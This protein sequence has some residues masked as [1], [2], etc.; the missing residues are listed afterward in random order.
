MILQPKIGELR[1]AVQMFRSGNVLEKGQWVSRAMWEKSSETVAEGE[2]PQLPTMINGEPGKI[3]EKVKVLGVE[4]EELRIL[5]ASGTAK[6]PREHLS[7]EIQKKYWG[8]PIARQKVEMVAGQENRKVPD[9]ADGTGLREESNVGSQNDVVLMK[10]PARDDLS[11]SGTEWLYR[12]LKLYKEN[13]IAV[14]SKYQGEKM[15]LTGEV[16]RVERDGSTQLPLILLSPPVNEKVSPPYLVVMLN[17]FE[18]A[19]TLKG[20]DIITLTGDYFGEQDFRGLRLSNGNVEKVRSRLEPLPWLTYEFVDED[21]LRMINPE[22]PI[23]QRAV[24]LFLWS[25]KYPLLKESYDAIHNKKIIEVFLQNSKGTHHLVQVCMTGTS[26]GRKVTTYAYVCVIEDGQ[27]SF[28]VITEND[29]DRLIQVVAHCG[30]EP[31]PQL[32]VRLM[33]NNSWPKS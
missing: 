10:R 31:V 17:S 1:R 25:T 27:G 5:H 33:S 15:T 13:P 9:S 19:A 8:A 12:L 24:E 2:F 4:A 22:D 21:N 11:F 14:D 16:V 3:Y 20:G 30:S 23:A 29:L 28:E 26:E 6:I 18:Q 7:E 32:K